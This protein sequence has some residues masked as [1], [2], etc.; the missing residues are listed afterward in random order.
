M[1]YSYNSGSEKPVIGIAM[2]KTSS[3]I[4]LGVFSCMLLLATL[5][6]IGCRQ[7]MQL[8]AVHAIQGRTMGTT[9]S[10]KYVEGERGVPHGKVAEAIEAELKLVNEQMS[11][12][13]QNSELSRFNQADST[14]WFEVSRETAE[15]VLL[16]LKTSE[17]SNG[18]FDVTVGPLVNLWGFGP[19]KG[20]ERVP[21]QLELDEARQ[22]VGYHQLHARLDPPSL[23]K[24]STHVYVDL[25]AIAKGHGVDRAAE[26]LTNF[27]IRDFFV[28]VGG[29]ISTSGLRVDGKPWQVGI[30][31]PVEAERGVRA[32]VGLSNQCMATSGDYRNY[33]EVDGQRFSHTIDPATGRPVTHSLASATVVTNNCAW[34]DALATS[35]MVLGPDKGIELAEQNDW[36][37]LLIV[38]TNN[39]FENHTSSAFAKLFPDFAKSNR[40]N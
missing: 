8:P 13:L 17:L 34:A 21:N 37:V 30:E 7:K 23:K 9:Y 3:I 28:E 1:N 10:I 32:I 5:I 36:A 38:R 26:V 18:A 25:S 20:L 14:D 4:R 22:Q 27:G 31:K 39:G 19:A 11:T 6:Q 12:Y 2:K 40:S 35:M 16:A 15:V 29:E 33:Y 24:D